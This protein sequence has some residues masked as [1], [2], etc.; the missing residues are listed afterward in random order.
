[1][2]SPRSKAAIVRRV[3]RPIQFIR[4]IFNAFVLPAWTAAS[5]TVGLIAGGL[6]RDQTLFYR[7]QRG[8]A[9]GLF[10]LCGIELEVSGEARMQPGTTYVVVAN[11]ASYMDI[12]ALFASLPTLPQIIAKREL[13]RLPFLG[14]ALRQGRHVLIER[15]RTNAS[16]LDSIGQVAAQV[17][18]GAVVLVFPE[19][20]RSVSDEIGR[21]KTGA[22]RIAK[23]AE[24][25]ILPVGISGTRRI[26]PKHGRLLRA[27]PVRVRI[28]EPLT[29][30]EVRAAN[31]NALSRKAR[32]AVAE[33]A[34]LPLAGIAQD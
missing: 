25:A 4:A 10:W 28:G 3:S 32:A 5:V 24:A 33:L 26:L 2:P 13:A 27:H 11:H 14:A 31:V 20:T 8:W 9:R 16:A 7:W 15:G 19:G 18:A 29:A 22:F 12:A 21:F 6:L 17:R 1:V 30:E 23:A 34:G